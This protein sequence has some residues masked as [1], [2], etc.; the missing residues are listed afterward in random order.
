MARVTAG[1]SVALRLDSLDVTNL[2]DGIITSATLNQVIIDIGGG[3]LE[4]FTGTGFAFGPNGLPT[5]GTITGIRE[6]L[7]GAV[8]FDLTDINVPTSQF[9]GWAQ[10]AATAT[11]LNTIFGG[12]DDI[13]GSLFADYLEG[14][15]GHDIMLGG[16]GADTLI[17]GAGNDHLYGQSPNGGD[18]GADVLLGGDGSDY[19]QGNAGADGLDGGAGSDRIMGGGGNDLILGDDGND[20]VNGNLGDDNIDGGTGNDSLRGGQGN[21]VIK[22]GDGHDILL[23][24]A[25][26]DTLT[27]GAGM[28]IFQIDRGGSLRITPDVITD[29]TDGVDHIALR[30]TDNIGIVYALRPQ[31]VRTGTADSYV[32]AHDVAVQLMGRDG[33]AGGVYAAV[34]VGNDTYVFYSTTPVLIESAFKLEGVAPSTVTPDDFI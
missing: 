16:A 17:G 8:T 31:E 9:V 2:V 14:F 11:A 6:T 4:T 13:R 15:G 5:G 29:F 33:P 27:G 23:G 32:A 10:T 3:Y 19:L 22:G 28:D 30:Y 18:D 20:T 25:G 7:N 34:G 1:T 12:N 21:D 24:D 26:A